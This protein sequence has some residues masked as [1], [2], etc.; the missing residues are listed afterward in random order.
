MRYF[1]QAFDRLMVLEGGYSDHPRDRGGE[2]RFGISAAAYPDLDI[3][4]LTKEEAREIY[5]RDYWRVL[6]CDEIWWPLSEILFVFGVHAGVKTAARLLQDAANGVTGARL[7]Q[8]GVIGPKTLAALEEADRVKLALGFVSNLL[9]HY[10]GCPDW[11]QWHDGW[12][13]RVARHLGWVA[14]GTA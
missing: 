2:T 11:W 13:N 8:D 1:N 4:N 12:V 14:A 7:R 5:L 9:N 3:A 10:R 6:R